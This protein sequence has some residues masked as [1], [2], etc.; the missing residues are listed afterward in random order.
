MSKSFVPADLII[1]RAS[2]RLKE[3]YALKDKEEAEYIYR[4]HYKT[5][6]R[7]KRMW[8]NYCPV[9]LFSKPRPVMDFETYRA[10]FNINNM[11][12]CEA[13]AFL[14]NT[15]S[16]SVAI[17]CMQDVLALA[18][19]ARYGD[20]LV[21]LSPKHCHELNFGK[22]VTPLPEAEENRLLALQELNEDT[23]VYEV[24]TR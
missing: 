21:E 19:A 8:N 7:A 24:S 12:V 20:G 13:F 4:H 16:Y 23:G 17:E 14:A 15:G 18:E 6:A 10:Q 22:Q 2:A 5:Y 11:A 3:L 1:D 9:F